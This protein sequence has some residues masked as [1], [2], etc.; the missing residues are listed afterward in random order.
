MGYCKNWV[1]GGSF[2]RCLA[3]FIVSFSNLQKAESFY[4]SEKICWENRTKF[5]V[6]SSSVKKK[7]KKVSEK[8]EPL[9]AE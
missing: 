9:T 8:K 1:S 2:Y 4:A 7:K 6:T 5:I 3:L